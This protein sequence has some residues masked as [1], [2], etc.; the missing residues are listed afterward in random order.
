MTDVSVLQ[1]Q[2]LVRSNLN[3]T[4]TIA[5]GM[6]RDSKSTFVLTFLLTQDAS[7]GVVTDNDHNV[8]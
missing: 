2:S 5:L 6:S 1:K 7:F 3:E 8:H 4:V